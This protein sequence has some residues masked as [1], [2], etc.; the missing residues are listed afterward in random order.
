MQKV[1]T[2]Q[3]AAWQA[4]L[5]ERLQLLGGASKNKIRGYGSWLEELSQE[6]QI[7]KEDFS[8]RA[9]GMIHIFF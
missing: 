1:S 4:E 8:I 9:F 6:L 2:E 3:E 5:K 7:M